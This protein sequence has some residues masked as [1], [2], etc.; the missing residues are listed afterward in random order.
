M[1]RD[2]ARRDVVSKYMV[3]DMARRD[4]VKRDVV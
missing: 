2:K 4:V 3:S 1:K